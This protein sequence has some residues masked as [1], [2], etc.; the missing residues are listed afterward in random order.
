[1]QV[2]EV[3]TVSPE[4]CRPDDNLA[5][6]VAQMWK[7]DAGVLP[8]LDHGGRLAGIVTDRD[9]CVALGTRNTRASETRVA[10]VMSNSVATCFPTDD[11]QHAL[12][13]M[14]ERRVRR[15]PVV[16]AEHR[17]LGI[18]S[19]SDVAHAAGA[20]AVRPGAVLDAFRTI[21]AHP[22]PAALPSTGAGEPYAAAAAAAPGPR[23]REVHGAS[24]T[25]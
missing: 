14:S 11:V 15:L 7:V 21:C 4:T 23:E 16:D 22:L 8:V 20:N 10:G 18:L 13:L 3:M 25:P 6:A 12:A 9:I 19:L 2:Q 5:Q 17:L 1:M 24:L